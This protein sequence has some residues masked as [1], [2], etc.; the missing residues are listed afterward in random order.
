MGF[1]GTL[2]RSSLGCHVRPDRRRVVACRAEAGDPGDVAVV[3]RKN[4]LKIKT[5]AEA[6]AFFSKAR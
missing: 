3:I 6:G 1:K 2:I 5:P 4:I